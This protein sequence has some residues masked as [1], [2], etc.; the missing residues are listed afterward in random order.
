MMYLD[1][2]PRR[3]ETR[4]FSAMPAEFRRPGVRSDWADANRGGH[5]VDSFIEGPAF[6]AAG[7]LYV[8]D[9]PF[10]RIFRI[11]P[12]G[13]WSLIAEYQGWP[14]GLKIAPD[15]RILVADY[16]N[17]IMELDPERG[18][19]RPL[20]AHRNS[21]SFK[22][23][24]DLHIASNGDVYF[25]DQGQTGLHD[26]SGRVFRLRTDSRLDCLI[27]NGPSPN[28]LVLSPDEAVLFVAMTRD[29]SVWRVPL[30]RDGG[31]A[32]VGRFASF[33]GTSGPDGLTMDRSG[34]LFVAHASLGHVFV[35]APNGG[36]IARIKSCAG[37][38]CTNVALDR[39][40]ETLMIT[41]SSSGSVLA[42]AL[43]L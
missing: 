12:D 5:P 29:N 22:G 8:V 41:E 43:D 28:G 42:A 38:T 24:N 25:T 35:L 17:G 14:N 30:M 4:L 27:A 32:K 39:T 33:F 19:I 26:P 31:V 20:L 11:A 40:G 3:L 23:C 16:V 36:C 1:T 15:G 2:P 37:P 10:G 6:D 13:T 18:T 21:E 9:I 7:N 34:R